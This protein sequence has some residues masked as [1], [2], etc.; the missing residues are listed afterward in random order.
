MIE[1]T[2][3]QPTSGVYF[4]SVDH[5]VNIYSS[6]FLSSFLNLLPVIIFNFLSRHIL[7]LI[8]T[9]GWILQGEYLFIYL[10]CVV[11]ICGCLVGYGFLVLILMLSCVIGIFIWRCLWIWLLLAVENL[12]SRYVSLSLLSPSVSIQLS[13]ILFLST[14]N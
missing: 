8:H 12:L 6:L 4:A 1:F 14:C 10:L 3:E 9:V 5:P 2:L 7:M 13:F 11:I